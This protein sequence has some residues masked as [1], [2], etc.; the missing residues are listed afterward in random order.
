MV[1]AE[2]LFA[3]ACVAYPLLIGWAWV[4][5]G[6]GDHGVASKCFWFGTLWLA[7]ATVMLGATVDWP[8][9]PR[10]VFVGVIGAGLLIGLT[11]SLRW[12]RGEAQA[13]SANDLL[14]RQGKPTMSDKPSTPPTP[15][16]GTVEQHNQAGANIGQQNNYYQTTS[17]PVHDPDAIHQAGATVGKVYGGRR[18][19]TDAT[20]YEFVEIKNANQLNAQ[21]PFEY[22][23]VTL[24]IQSVRSRIGLDISRAQDGMV[25][26]G[27]IARV[28]G[29]ATQ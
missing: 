20:L 3:A 29:K 16:I 1:F 5:I 14:A 11:E 27:V 12:A 7:G 25:Y 28:V 17:K 2:A 19:P 10:L 26:G 24:V 4:V 21:A 6:R 18:S 23:G 8:V 13:P 22:D 15:A 9:L